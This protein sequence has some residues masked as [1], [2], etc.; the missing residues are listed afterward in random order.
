[1]Y[2]K[3]NFNFGYACICTELRKKNIFSSRTMRLKT[4]Q[5]KGIKYAQELSLKNL[6]D[7]LYML[8]WNIENEIYF[9]RISSD[10]FPFA[11]HKDYG[12]SIDF[13]DDI[14]KKIGDFAKTNKIRL[15]M[16]PGQY[17]VLS[18]PSESVIITLLTQN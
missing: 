6:N 16:H 9:M 17:N 18:S 5:E 10:I 2:N 14:L 1:M 15:T 13:A 8:K 7:L 12:Y 4:L 11:S 3:T